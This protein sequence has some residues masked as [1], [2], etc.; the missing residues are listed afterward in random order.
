MKI[1]LNGMPR[2]TFRTLHKK[3]RSNSICLYYVAW[4]VACNKHKADKVLILDF[5][6]TFM[7]KKTSR[8][9]ALRQCTE[10]HLILTMRQGQNRLIQP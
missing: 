7:T 10:I 5:R 2:K 8:E 1:A 9:N 3:G 6:L 4:A